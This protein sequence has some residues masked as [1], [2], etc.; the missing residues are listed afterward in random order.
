MDQHSEREL[1]SI[2]KFIHEIEHH[3]LPEADCQFIRQPN[4]RA[5]RAYF[6]ARIIILKA[7]FVAP[8]ASHIHQQQQV[9]ESNRPKEHQKRADETK[10]SEV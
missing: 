8:I 1:V 10:R 7:N 3:L 5:F 6:V 9:I 2:Q 4:Y